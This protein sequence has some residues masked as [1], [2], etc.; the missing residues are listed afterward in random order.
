MKS[1]AKVFSVFFVLAMFVYSP[2]ALGAAKTLIELKDGKPVAGL[3]KSW[4]KVKDGEYEFALDT[5]V[6]LTG[7]K[8][9]TAGAVKS[10][11]ESKLGTSHGVKVTAKGADSVTVTYTC[12]EPKF[13][14]QMSKT[15]I[16]AQS[17]E[18]AL[19]SSSE[20]GIRARKPGA[21]LAEGEVKGFVSKVN[22]DHLVVKIGE[23]KFAGLKKDESIK[24]K[25]VFK[26]I[27]KNENVFFKPEAKTG[28]MWTPVAGSLEK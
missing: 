27:K 20:G 10:S 19:E 28:D 26:G 3:A 5:S 21:P 8:A 4:K 17:T 24:V 7:G 14:D 11:L 16:R 22:K 12:E 15:R 13:L 1:V 23:T 18:I 25:G 2:L 6:E 9:L